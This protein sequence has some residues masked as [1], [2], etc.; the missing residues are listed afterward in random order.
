MTLHNQHITTSA[1]RIDVRLTRE[2]LDALLFVLGEG[3]EPKIVLRKARD[4][5]SGARSR[6]GPDETPAGSM[7]ASRSIR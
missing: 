4:K 1:R 7:P 2:E 6:L 5:I 3:H